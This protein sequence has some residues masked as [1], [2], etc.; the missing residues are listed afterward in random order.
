MSLSLVSAEAVRS[1]HYMISDARVL[2]F[3]MLYPSSDASSPRRC[4]RTH[5][6]VMCE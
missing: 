3:K 2:E 6:E 1:D 5:V 4:L